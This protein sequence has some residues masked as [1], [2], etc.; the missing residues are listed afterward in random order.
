MPIPYCF[1][2]K[3]TIK[4]MWLR[5]NQFFKFCTQIIKENKNSISPADKFVAYGYYFPKEWN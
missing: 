3:L 2:Y 5:K 4:L 1:C